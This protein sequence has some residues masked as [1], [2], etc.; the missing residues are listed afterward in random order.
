MIRWNKLITL[1]TYKIKK[2]ILFSKSVK[3]LLDLDL[4][5]NITGILHI[6]N[7]SK[8]D[9]VQSDETHIL[10]GQEYF[11]ESI[12]GL[13]FKITPFSFFQTNP[14]CD[15]YGKSIHR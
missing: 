2:D 6:E 7:D 5:G 8:A 11:Y 1:H 13:K 12:L 4:D 9:V 3:R 15:S 10:Y 14:F